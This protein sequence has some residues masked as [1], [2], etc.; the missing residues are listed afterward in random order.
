MAIST[1]K[2]ANRL[3][4]QASF[5]D[6]IRFLMHDKF[7][8]LLDESIE[9]YTVL[10][11]TGIYKHFR[12]GFVDFKRALDQATEQD[13]TIAGV[14]SLFDYET[15]GRK[16]KR[17]TPQLLGTSCNGTSLCLKTECFGLVEGVIENNNIL[18]NF[19]WDLGISCIKD[20]YYS[21]RNF[22][23]KI[24]HYFSAFFA[25]P[26]AV[27]QA[28]QRTKLLKEAVK[29]VCTAQNFTYTGP[30]IGGSNHL[31]LPFYINPTD[32]TAMPDVDSIAGGIGGANLAAFMRYVL[33]SLFSGNFGT[34]PDDFTVY[35]L[36]DDLYT[37]IEQTASVQDSDMAY[38][39]QMMLAG[40]NN[41]GGVK[42][43]ISNLVSDKFVRDEY[44]PTFKLDG[45][46]VL[47][48][49][50]A[51]SLLNT[52]LQGYQLTTNPDHRLQKF[53]ALLFV[54]SNW[55][56]DLVM[57]PEDNYSDILG[58]GPVADFRNNTP[59]VF[60][61]SSSLFSRNRKVPG[62]L[63]DIIPAGN[64]SVTMT[65]ITPR[66]EGM[67]PETVR[68]RVAMTFSDT[69]A[70]NATAGQLNNV[71]RAIKNQWEADGIAMHSEMYVKT[72]VKGAA[73]P[74]LLVFETDAVRPATPIRVCSTNTITVNP[75][76]GASIVSCCPGTARYAHLTYNTSVASTYAVNDLVAF[77]TGAKG[78]TFLA[79][80][81]AVAGSVVTIESVDSAGANTN[82]IIPCCS[83]SPDAY[84]NRGELVKLAGS[85]LTSSEIMQ[86]EW[87]TGTS[88][89]LLQVY[90]PLA[91]KTTAATGT[92]TL[93]TGDVINVVPAVNGVGVFWSVVAAG[94]E[95]CN[96]ATISCNSLMRAVLK[97][98]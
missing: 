1:P 80:V 4:S 65:G 23:D 14:G 7:P 70:N 83:D 45:N 55:M 35:G 68:T 3:P 24:V 71:G 78:D 49:V 66:I 27:M 56:F 9:Y 13:R 32:A 57:P 81:T 95:T 11:S 25:Q 97:W 15:F 82:V 58:V 92:I 84:G 60:N 69:S 90:Q 22:E 50:Q 77:R 21:D 67:V 16:I 94:G 91:A 31:P 59:G 74:V 42:D 72:S 62:K 88:R 41:V 2:S 46:N 61:L 52:T 44:F 54:P 86:A 8:S 96:L 98:N 38:M 39:L 18:E 30:L 33:P 36:Q 19:C 87:D 93:E 17:P 34:G 47:E 63:V 43:K 79:K 10:P 85:T 48:V 5:K 37:A 29:V 12:P 73:R 28:Y 51:D 26:M 20:L 53:R 76:A 89:L 64:S 40:K 75:T 6:S